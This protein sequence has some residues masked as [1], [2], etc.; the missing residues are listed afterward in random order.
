VI[1][2]EFRYYCA[3]LLNKACL[4]KSN[5]LYLYMKNKIINGCYAVLII[6]GATLIYFNL[7]AWLIAVIV[8]WSALAIVV[9]A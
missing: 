5:K 7:L 4:I 6:T 1:Y 9:N 8:V 3:N 2:K